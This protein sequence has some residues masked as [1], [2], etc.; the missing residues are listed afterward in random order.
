MADVA[1]TPE[2]R[3]EHPDGTQI[4]D[5]AEGDTIAITQAG[6]TLTWRVAAPIAAD[7][8]KAAWTFRGTPP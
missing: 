2:D 8:A 7:P 5:P 4:D 3:V 1:I 6:Q